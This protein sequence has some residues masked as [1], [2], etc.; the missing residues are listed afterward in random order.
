M[1]GE[2]QAAPL[3]TKWKMDISVFYKQ[4]TPDGVKKSLFQVRWPHAVFGKLWV[5]SPRWLLLNWELPDPIALGKV[6]F[7]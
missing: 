5:S 4:V 6:R 1:A 7:R 2:V 3:K